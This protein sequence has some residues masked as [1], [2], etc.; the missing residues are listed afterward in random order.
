MYEIR[1]SLC[2]LFHSGH[3][4]HEAYHRKKSQIFTSWKSLLGIVETPR[5]VRFLGRFIPTLSLVFSSFC[6]FSGVLTAPCVAAHIRKGLSK[7]LPLCCGSYQEIGFRDIAIVLW[8]WSGEFFRTFAH[9]VVALIIFFLI[10]T[11][12]CYICHLGRH[13]FLVRRVWPKYNPLCCVLR[14][15]THALIMWLFTVLLPHVFWPLSED[16]LQNYYLS[17]VALIKRVVLTKL[18]ILPCLNPL[19][20]DPL[21]LSGEY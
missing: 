7:L 18:L 19:W 9:C 1:R 10:T 2:W 16:R 13:L 21:L 12:P 4:L 8:H 5:K 3:K 11:I 17:D 15:T 14:G 6:S 20:A